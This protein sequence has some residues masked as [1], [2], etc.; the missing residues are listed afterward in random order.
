MRRVRVFNALL[1]AC[2]SAAG[3][4]FGQADAKRAGQPNP[5]LAASL[6]STKACPFSIIGV[7]K[8]D[9][10]SETNPIF[11]SFAPT[12]W[13]TVLGH[14]A[15]ALPQD[16]DM[17]A[18]V[19]YKLDDPGAPTRIEFTAK[20][21][22]DTFPRGTSSLEI[23]QFSADSFTIADLKTGQRTLWERV[24][25]QRYFLT[26]AARGL[27][28]PQLGP[29]FALWTTLDG[30][31]TEVEALGVQLTSD[32]KGKTV[33]M[34]G[35]IQ[36]ELYTEFEQDIGSESKGSDDQKVTDSKVMMRLELSESEFE[37]TH[38]ILE[39]WEK[40][41]KAKAL[42]NAD[43]Y[44]NAME[45]LTRTAQ[46]LNQCEE[47]IKLHKPDT[48]RPDDAIARHKVSQRPLEYIRL[49]R[50]KNDELHVSDATF[51]WAW[52]PTIALSQ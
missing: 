47:R 9:A 6:D 50:K 20:G 31:K 7:W 13:V 52:R 46:S 24:Q 21:K 49:M 17:M 41:V 42:P 10:T 37:R 4:S 27:R 2:L 43:P 22:N 36:D 28:L 3:I 12:G 38:K 23:I 51:P 34:F 39:T 40:Y 44:L 29:A 16:F 35:P 19:E 1:F 48:S 14:I 45:F 5:T 30:R 26:F 33:A 18:Q 15:G 11:Y 25:A 8:S 32:E